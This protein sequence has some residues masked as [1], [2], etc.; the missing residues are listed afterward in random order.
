MTLSTH[1]RDLL[2]ALAIS[3]D[4]RLAQVFD[5]SCYPLSAPPSVSSA[6]TE[7]VRCA[8]QSANLPSFV[9]RT[10]LV[11]LRKTLR[12]LAADALLMVLLVVDSRWVIHCVADH[13]HIPMS[14]SP[15]LFCGAAWSPT[16]SRRGISCWSTRC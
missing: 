4:E 3:S 7:H 10:L 5:V 14:V 12:Q 9:S 13:H 8:T 15:R 1:A 16:H 6:V 11:S 2:V